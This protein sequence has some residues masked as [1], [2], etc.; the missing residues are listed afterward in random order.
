MSRVRG[1]LLNVDGSVEF[2]IYCMAGKFGRNLI[3]WIGL[4]FQLV[5]FNLA[6][7]FLQAMMSYIYR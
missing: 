3:W 1:Q 2:R 4:Q 5:D 6:V 7:L